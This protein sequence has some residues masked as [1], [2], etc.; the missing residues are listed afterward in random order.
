MR[1]KITLYSCLA[2]IGLT[3]WLGTQP[4]LADVSVAVLP[5]NQV[6]LVGSTAAFNAQVST[7]G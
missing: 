7:T 2:A 6:V 3:F 1:S 5:T 4:A